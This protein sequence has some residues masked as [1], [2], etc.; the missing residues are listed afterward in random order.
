[1]LRRKKTMESYKYAKPEK[2]RQIKRN[3]KKIYH[4]NTDQ[5][6]A[7]VKILFQKKSDFKKRKI[8][9]DKEDIT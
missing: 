6:N 3:G 8:I 4:T 9:S 2:A 5:K 7:R 1:M